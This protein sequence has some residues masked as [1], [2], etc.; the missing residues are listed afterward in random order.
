MPATSVSTG[1]IDCYLSRMCGKLH[2]LTAGSAASVAS[3]V[4]SVTH[5]LHGLLASTSR[6]ESTIEQ[7]L[8]Y[9]TS[10]VIARA[11]H[12]TVQSSSDKR[13]GTCQGE[14][15]SEEDSVA[16]PIKE[17]WNVDSRLRLAAMVV[18]KVRHLYTSGLLRHK[19][20]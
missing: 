7:A 6:S 5:K 14:I 12:L 18:A 20:Y 16:E 13:L 4:Q 17:V 3:R 11:Y 10:S 2:Q 15:P 1:R 9:A 19:Y 8:W